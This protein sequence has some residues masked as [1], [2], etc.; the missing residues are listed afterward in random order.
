M[1][2]AVYRVIAW[3]GIL[4]AAVVSTEVSA[5]QESLRINKVKA[6]FVL[7]V[8]RFVTWPTDLTNNNLPVMLCYYRSNPFA[9]GLD[10]IRGQTVNGKPLELR[11]IDQLSEVKACQILLVPQQ[12]LEIFSAEVL[13]GLLNSVLTFVDSTHTVSGPAEG[14]SAYR[15]P[16][17]MV[18]LVRK[19]SRIGFEINLSAT[20][21]AGLKMNSQLLKHAFI[22]DGKP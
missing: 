8:S 20:H 22:V 17:I 3:L 10:S 18:S 11:R 15:R 4:C 1:S 12:Q 19:G 13:P 7:N 2:L 21:T 5:D 6:A 16:G 14:Q 9:E